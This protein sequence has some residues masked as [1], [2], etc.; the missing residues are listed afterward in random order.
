MKAIKKLNF[1]SEKRVFSDTTFKVIKA[2]AEMQPRAAVQDT[3]S[4]RGEDTRQ[5]SHP[6]AQDK[7][8]KNKGTI[9]VTKCCKL[10]KRN[11]TIF[12]FKHS[13]ALSKEGKN[14]IYMQAR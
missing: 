4:I 3:S 12:K 14:P 1:P 7:A 8:V 5:A 10:F 6:T 11:Y 9:F 2:V 13:S